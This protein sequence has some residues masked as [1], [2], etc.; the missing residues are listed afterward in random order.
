MPDKDKPK[1]LCQLV[2]EKLGHQ[3][4]DCHEFCEDLQLYAIISKGAG[5][6]D[7]E[8]LAVD[9][10]TMTAERIDSEGNVVEEYTIDV[11]VTKS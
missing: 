10:A 8:F 5:H 1:D 11:I 4:G 7:G 2:A 9:P 6:P 3:L